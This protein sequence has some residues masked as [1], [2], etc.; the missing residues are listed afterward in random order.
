MYILHDTIAAY[1][2]S[3]EE[4]C[5][6]MNT[7]K[8]LYCLLTHATPMLQPQLLLIYEGKELLLPFSANIVWSILAP[9][10]KER[11]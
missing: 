8:T 9:D 4:H 3:L 1:S 7:Q 11:K 5:L 2:L 10:D 6:A